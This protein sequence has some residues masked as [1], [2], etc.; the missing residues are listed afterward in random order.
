VGAAAVAALLDHDDTGAAWHLTGPVGITFADVARGLGAR[1]LDVP[2]RLARK[3]LRRRGA[4]SFEI[5][6]TLRM[7][8]YFASGADGAP[9][10]AV[11]RLTGHPP[12]SLDHYL[13][14]KGT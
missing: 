13:T 9:T 10:D 2:P 12:R 4:S 7:A 8:A 6:H 11:R 3:A 1:Y 14:E 5:D